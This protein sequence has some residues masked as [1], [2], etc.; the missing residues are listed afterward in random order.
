[1]IIGEKDAVVMGDIAAAHVLSALEDKQELLECRDE[2]ER[3]QM[4]ESRLNGELQIVKLE[5]EIQSKVSATIEQHNKDYYLREQIRVIHEELGD[6]EESELEELHRKLEAS[7][8][9]AGPR[10]AV[11]R[12]LRKAEHLAPGSP[13]KLYGFQLY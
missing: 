11:E 2:E 4:L 7:P 3:L 10:E 6:T 8:M 1:M 9:P 5:H 12:E 13:G